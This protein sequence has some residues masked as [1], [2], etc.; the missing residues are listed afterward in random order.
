MAEHKDNKLLRIPTRSKNLKHLGDNWSES[1]MPDNHEIVPE[2]HEI[3]KT[4][5]Q[6]LNERVQTLSVKAFE[7][8][9]PEK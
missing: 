4:A 8:K 7:N 6:I 9:N 3:H 1:Y 2:K 5:S